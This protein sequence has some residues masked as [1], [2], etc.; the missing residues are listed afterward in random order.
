MTDRKLNI[1]GKLAEFFITSKLTVLFVLA[2]ILIGVLAITLTPREENPQIIVPAA[3]VRVLLPGASAA[4]VEELIIRPIEGEIK[5]IPGID[6]VYATAMNSMGGVMVQFKVGENKEQS[7][8]RLY[9]C[10]LGHR[11]LLPAEAGTPLIRSVDVDDV[12]VVTVTLA[13]EK[14]D[15]YALKRLADRMVD[16]LRSQDSVSVAYVKGGRDREIRI[17]LD[18]ER[19]QAF[20]VTLDQVRTLIT[21]GNVSAPLGTQVQEGQNHKV[22]LDGFLTSEDDL[23]HLIVSANAGRPIYLGDVAHIVDAP[24]EERDTLTRLAYGPADAHF[25]KT[26]QPEIPAVT[27]AVAKKRGTNAVFFANDLLKRIDRMKAQ[28]VPPGVDVVVTRNDGQ[29]ANDAVNRLIGHLGIAT[30]TVFVVTVLFLGFREAVIVG[31]TIPLILALTLGGVHLFGITINRITLYAFIMLM[32]LVVDAAIVVIEN[33]HRNYGQHGQNDKRQVTVQSTNEVGNPTNLATLAV[34]IVALSLLPIL[35]GMPG[36]YFHPVGITGPLAMAFSLLVAYCVVPWAANRWLKPAEAHDPKKRG[37][38]NRLS[39]YYRADVAPFLSSAKWRRNLFLLVLTMTALSLLQPLWQFIRPGG[40]SGPQSFFGTEMS[41]LPKDN[42][43]TLNITIDMPE[44]APLETTDQI[45]REIGALLRQTPEV[46]NYQISLGEAGVID[47]N[48]LLRG[49]GSKMGSYVA[50]IRVNLSDKKTRSRTSIDIAREM[51]LRIVPI[52]A[53]YPG[54][55]V[56]VVE[57]PPGPP[58]RATVLAEIYGRD[59]QQLRILSQRVKSAFQQT[60]DMAEVK[61]SEVEDVSEYHLVVDREKAAMSGI[62]NGE[63][64]IALRRLIDGEVMGDAHIPGE[65]NPVPIR[66]QIPRRYQIDPTLLS[67]ITVTNRQGQQVALSELVQVIPAWADRPIQHQDDERVTYVGGELASTASVYA[68]LDLDRRLDGMALPDG[69]RLVTGNLRPYKADPDTINGYRLHW[70]G[71]MRLMLDSYRDLVFALALSIVSIFLILVAYY[72]SFTLPIIAMSAI[73]LGLVGIFPGHWL[74]GK[75][76]TVTSLVGI[77]TLTGILVR[78]SLLII[79]F[80]LDYRR[81]GMDFREAILEAGAVRLRPI[82]LTTLAIV[83]GSM[84]MLIDPVFCGLGISLIF[85][86]LA[87]TVLTLVVIPCLLFLHFKR[88]QEGSVE[89]ATTVK[90][91][92]R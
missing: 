73:P 35:T 18:P 86:T 57:D 62:T 47:F 90:D 5:E 56:Q 42:T 48:G 6:H 75:P 3:E 68:V 22:V 27:I 19:M 82:L 30:L 21:A 2:C 69:S 78:N 65:K 10:I 15:D 59:P 17:E 72:Q 37:G 88:E 16:G 25:G 84:V 1:A 49:S 20:G 60:Y 44:T 12:P 23:K 64:A 51:R 36:Q 46:R 52:A 67:R 70:G 91:E 83:F 11:D 79:D 28:F 41:F 89:Q 38:W 24:P 85:G 43:N 71:E 39:R 34:M 81:Q 80:A 50:E 7:L 87:A 45:A 13:S 54:S 63:V 26:Q 9:D 29:K 8:V 4:E 33:I 61:S 55:T 31:A 76:F 92:T 58:V 40:M 14:Y 74:L 66:L 53:R 32:G 77:L